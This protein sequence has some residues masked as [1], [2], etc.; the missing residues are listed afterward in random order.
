MSKL[1]VP[2][3]AKPSSM[4][5]ALTCRKPCWC[6]CT[7]T[8][9]SSSSLTKNWAAGRFRRREVRGIVDGLACLE[10]PVLEEDRLKLSHGRA[11]DAHHQLAIVADVL[12]AVVGADDV[13]RAGIGDAAVDDGELAMVAQVD[14]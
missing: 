10:L 2:S 11:D 9:Y 8:P 6:R 12:V 3:M 14:A 5:M 13:L 7:W 4:V 1:A